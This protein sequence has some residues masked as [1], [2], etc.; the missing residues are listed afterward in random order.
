MDWAE[1]VEACLFWDDRDRCWTDLNSAQLL[2][3]KS[4][5]PCPGPPVTTGGEGCGGSKCQLWKAPQPLLS[6]PRRPCGQ[7]KEA[8][9][10]SLRMTEP[11]R[12]S[13]SEE[14]R[15][16]TQSRQEPAPPKLG[17]THQLRKN[18]HLIP[19]VPS[20]PFNIL[21]PLIHRKSTRSQVG[22]F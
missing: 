12:A 2:P 20:Q 9:P 8:L 21:I 5:C 22:A 10:A 15:L 3:S 11:W 17:S 13:S 18:S 4:K 16:H 6:P 1:E 19:S 7:C 14:A